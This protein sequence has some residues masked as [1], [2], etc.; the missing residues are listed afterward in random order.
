[1]SPSASAAAKSAPSAD[2]VLPD[3]PEFGAPLPITVSPDTLRLLAERRSSSAQTLAA[4]GPTPAQLQDLIRLAARVP[5]H[6]KLNP[7]RFVIMEGEA[8]ARLV[9]RLRALTPMQPNPGK[10]E[11]ALMKL[12]AP[13]VS[14][15][16]VFSEKPPIKPVWEQQLS[17]AAVCMTFLIA[18]E[19]M[20]FGANWITD[21]Y[22]Y[23]EAGGAALGL[24]SNEKVAGF[25]HLGTPT[26]PPLERVRPDLSTLV[27]RL[28]A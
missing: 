15:M 4:P 12:S 8:K 20:G 10:A 23:D 3:P 19:A 11:A 17:S 16:V 25:I 5:D 6:G 28:E 1:M 24:Q 26:E 14:V 22:S 18:A 27:T 21:W 13:P 2:S 7:W 9:E